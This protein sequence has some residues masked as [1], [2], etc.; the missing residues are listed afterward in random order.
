MSLNKY[1]SS[2]E[3]LCGEENS[4][5]V[6]LKYSFKDICVDK[7]LDK[8]D[9]S[10]LRSPYL[11]IAKYKDIEISIFKSGILIFR[12]IDDKGKLN[13]LLEELLL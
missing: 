13:L 9:A 11:T 7:I 4:Y 1:L 8:V 5:M 12:G 10:N 2:V 3:K 6:R